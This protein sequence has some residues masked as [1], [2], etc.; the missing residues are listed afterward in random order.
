MTKRQKSFLESLQKRKGSSKDRFRIGLASS[1]LAGVSDVVGTDPLGAE[2]YLGMGGYRSFQNALK[3][4]ESQPVYISDLMRPTVTDEKDLSA[5]SQ[6]L[7]K[8]YAKQAGKACLKFEA[9]ITST[10]KDRD[11]D[12][13][14][15]KGATLDP[16]MPLLWQHNAAQPIGRHLGVVGRNDQKIKSLLAIA[17]MPLG[18]DAACL[19][20]FDA[21]RISH[22]FN[23]NTYEPL[24]DEE[25]TKAGYPGWHV[26]EFEI[27]EVSLVS[28]PSNTDAVITAF[29][30]GKLHTA[31]VKGWAK[32]L[33]EKKKTVST[34]SSKPGVKNTGQG[35]V[36]VNLNLGDAT[37]NG[38]GPASRIK[39]LQDLIDGL[40][41][42]KGKKKVAK[43]DEDEEEKGTKAEDEEE[44]P[45]ARAEEEEGTLLESVRTQ[46][47]SLFDSESLDDE[48]RQSVYTMILRVSEAIGA[49]RAEGGATADADEMDEAGDDEFMTFDR[50][51]EPEEEEDP[52]EEEEKPEEDEEEEEDEDEEARK[53]DQPGWD[54]EDED[55]QNTGTHGPP[56]GSA[57]RGF[58]PPTV[59]AAEYLILQ[60]RTGRTVPQKTL[61]RLQSAVEKILD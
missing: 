4:A 17:D 6:E 36:T 55:D 60:L 51:E 54:G 16:A 22:G 30:R 21:L 59:D 14:E 27:C 1:Y 52:E 48:N 11:G 12:V 26:T 33:W 43:E 38:H 49:E 53:E 31:L 2:R 7:L 20:E 50:D 35:N 40:L 3:E 39:G 61:E 15:S 58:H 13:L 9:I 24:E 28:I 29:S 23:P 47:Q 32:R 37:T 18:H 56:K 41:A 5:K 25:S 10:R 57:E 8:K 19:V 42:K 45:E 46:L 34:P 44:E